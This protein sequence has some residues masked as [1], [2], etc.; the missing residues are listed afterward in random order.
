VA[1]V[2]RIFADRGRD[3]AA[4]ITEPVLCNSGCLLPGDGYLKGL[5][6]LSTKNGSLLIFDEVITGFR[7]DLRGAQGHYGVTPDLA[8]FGKAM[9]GGVPLSAFAGRKEILDLMYGGGVAY[10][11]TFNGNPLSLAGARATLDELSKDDGEPL[12]SANRGGERLKARIRDSAGKYGVPLTITGFGAAFSLHFTRKTA[13][14]TY[15]DVLSDDAA[16]LKRFLLAALAE[17]VYLLPDGRFY[18]SV[19][20]QESDIDETAAALD[21]V[22][23]TLV[24]GPLGN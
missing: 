14:T 4:V 5:R 24:S 15:R 21:R 8:T 16:M 6:D 7:M 3:I 20:H 1:A 11:G 12:R 9:G 2:E 10:G 18:V 19:A 17:G 13:L 22:F 23:A